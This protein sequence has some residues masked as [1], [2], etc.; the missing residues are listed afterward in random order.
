MKHLKY[1]PAILWMCLIFY[2]SSRTDLPKAE[3]FFWEFIF[4][5]SGHLF[6][7]FILAIIWLF[8]L[9]KDIIANAFLF[10]VTYAFSDEIHQLFVP[11]RTGLLRDVII[12]SVGVIIAITLFTI[13]QKWCQKP[14]TQ[15]PTKKLKI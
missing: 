13:Y 9:K 1:I 10:S 7:Y 6:V 11:G 5:K 15:V 12:D 2:L 4:K 3:N 14:F 8:T